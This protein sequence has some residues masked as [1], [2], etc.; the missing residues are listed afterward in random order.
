MGNLFATKAE[1]QEAAGP[2]EVLVQVDARQFF[3]QDFLSR[4]VHPVKDQRVQIILAGCVSR[5]H[6][7]LAQV[8]LACLSTD[9]GV[10]NPDGR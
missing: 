6:I 10:R 7:V 5:E 2:L 1:F 9:L 8:Q 4:L 3:Q